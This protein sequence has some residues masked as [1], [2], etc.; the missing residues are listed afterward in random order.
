M[1]ITDK[2]NFLPHT[3]IFSII[4]SGYC[5]VNI[6]LFFAHNRRHNPPEPTDLQIV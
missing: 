5:V 6:L 2:P 3:I 4:F 1:N